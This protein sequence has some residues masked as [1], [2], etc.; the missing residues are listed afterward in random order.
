[1]LQEIIII[2]LVIVL[3]WLLYQYIWKPYHDTQCKKENII[4]DAGDA[5]KQGWNNVVS[6]VKDDIHGID[7]L[8]NRNGRNRQYS[9]YRQ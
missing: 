4:K 3:L 9:E 8:N 1:M 7:F 2:I 6:E 5:I